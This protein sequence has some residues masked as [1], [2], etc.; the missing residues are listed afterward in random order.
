[1]CSDHDGERI[2]KHKKSSIKGRKEKIVSSK[3]CTVGTVREVTW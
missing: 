2:S 1:M 3:L